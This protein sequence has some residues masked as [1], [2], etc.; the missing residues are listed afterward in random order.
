MSHCLKKIS[1][2]FSGKKRAGNGGL[3]W[4]RGTSRMGME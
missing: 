4:K 1:Y 3:F 2:S